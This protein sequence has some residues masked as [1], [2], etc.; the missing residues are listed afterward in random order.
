MKYNH[1]KGTKKISI[2][3][4]R[5]NSHRKGLTYEDEFGEDK[6]KE[7]REKISKSKYGI[8]FT[9]G[10]RKKLSENHVNNG[11]KKGHKPWNYIDGR[12]K[13]LNPARY[14][15]DWDKIRYLV[16]LRDRFTCQGC[17][18]KGI[19][20]DIHHKVPF[21]ISKDNSL[22][23]LITLCRKCHMS[24]ERNIIIQQKQGGAYNDNYFSK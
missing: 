10:W 12:S 13:L 21:L 7:I 5:R 4:K 18:V 1:S 19:R 15:D 16:Y 23:N 24:I 8:V 17:G 14:G 2:V 6:A 22:D 9:D 11:F 20:L 3:M